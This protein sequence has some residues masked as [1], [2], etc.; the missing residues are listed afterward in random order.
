M[1]KGVSVDGDPADGAGTLSGTRSL[2]LAEVQTVALGGPA[3]ATRSELLGYLH[4]V[5]VFS[6]LAMQVTPETSEDF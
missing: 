4:I 5:L 1:D 3:A 2:S 6:G